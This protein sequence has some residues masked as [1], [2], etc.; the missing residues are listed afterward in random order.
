MTKADLV[1]NLGTIAKSGTKSF[2]EALSAGADVSM[3][4]QFGVG[5]YSAY[6]VAE[7]VVVRTKHNDDEALIWESAAGGSFTISQDDGSLGEPLKRGTSIVLHLKDDQIHFAEER[8]IKDLVK[9]HSEFIQ[10]P[11][12][13]WTEKEVEKD[14]DEDTEMKDEPSESKIEEVAAETK[15]ED[16]KEEGEEW[17]KEKKKFKEKVHEWTLLNKQKPIWTRKPS[18]V[19]P[20]ENK[21]L[22]KSLT[23]DWEDHLAVKNFSAEGNLEFIAVLFTPRRAPFDLFE[24]RKKLNNIKL[25]VK[26]VFIMDNCEELIPEWLGFIKGI[27]DPEDLPLNI[28]REMLQQNKILKVIRKPMIKKRMEMFSELSED[29]DSYKIFYEQLTLQESEVG[30]PR[31]RIQPRKAG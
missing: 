20:E 26:R 3:I 10:Y 9:K 17:K 27:V 2:M 5:F 25:Y 8:Q 24:P 1:N 13:L 15:V 7:K 28:S 18:E 14:V 29:K 6:F 22:Y 21:S 30:H 16:V 19:T 23:N 4:G 11:I 12:L 31:R